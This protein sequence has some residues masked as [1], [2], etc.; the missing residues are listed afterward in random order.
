MTTRTTAAPRTRHRIFAALYERMA[1]GRSMAV[2]MD[3]MRQETAGEARG[4]VLEVGAGTGLNFPFYEAERVERVEAVELDDY[5]LTY[6]RARIPL[7]QVPITLTQASVASLP[8]PDNTFDTAVATLV[9]CSVDDP[10]LGLREVRRVLKP[11]GVFF[12]VE[13]VRSASSV[14]ARLQDALVPLTTL[15]SGNCH[16]NRATERL[17]AEA[18]FHV[19]HLRDVPGLLHPF[20]V[21]K[22]TRR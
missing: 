20:V 12:L 7:A 6:A 3:P 4:V 11:D 21:L 18:G 14:A 5:M 16:W 15:T 17:V 13:H 1:R 19:E 22:A 2:M 8:F 10:P 9:F